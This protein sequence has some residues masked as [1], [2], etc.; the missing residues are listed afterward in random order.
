MLAQ[1]CV[2]GLLLR[3]KSYRQYPAFT[4]FIAFCNVRSLVLLYMAHEAF[5]MYERAF[6]LAYLPQLVLLVMLVVEV[7]QSLFAPTNT[8]PRGTLV[9]FVEAAAGCIVVVVGLTI[10]YPGQPNAMW[11]MVL[12][13]MDQATAWVMLAIFGL[14]A[15][16]A[17]FFGIPWR[18]RLYGIAVG[19]SIY[20]AVD[21]AVA[22]LAAQRDLELWPVDMVA[23]FV[24]CL[25]WVHYFGKAE[26]QREPLTGEQLRHLALVLRSVRSALSETYQDKVLEGGSDVS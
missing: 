4:S 8:L 6:W 26:V 7:F 13:A 14:V 10:R 9:H 20:L 1:A 21:C 2:L 12:W 18:H 17:Q 3:G 23:F 22:T 11:V 5:G 19:L 24:A 15:I 16:L 25:I